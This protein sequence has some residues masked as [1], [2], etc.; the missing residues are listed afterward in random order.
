MANDRT[1]V[2]M[3]A[4]RRPNGSPLDRIDDLPAAAISTVTGVM[5]DAFVIEDSIGVCGIWGHTVVEGT[6]VG[7]TAYNQNEAGEPGAMYG[8]SIV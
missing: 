6:H 5:Y 7:S 1:P 3:V 2:L 4:R 8:W